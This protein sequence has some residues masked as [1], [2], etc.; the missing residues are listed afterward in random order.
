[1][2]VKL[3]KLFSTFPYYVGW[4]YELKKMIK[5]LEEHKEEFDAVMDVPGLPIENHK[6]S[7]FIEH[8]SP[9]KTLSSS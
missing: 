4:F 9:E 8:G 6:F 3:T 1:M 5:I 7:V 2:I